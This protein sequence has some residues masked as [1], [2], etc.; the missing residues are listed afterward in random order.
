MNINFLLSIIFIGLSMIYF[1]FKPMKIEKLDSKEIPLFNLSAFTLYELDINSLTS[2]MK[3]SQATRYINRYEVK[4]INYTD[5]SSELQSN[6]KAKNGLYKDE[7][8][9]LDGDVVYDR[10]DGLRYFSQKAVY[11]KGENVIYSKAD[12][13]ATMGENVINGDYIYYDGNKEKIKSNNVY[14]V[15]K[16]KENK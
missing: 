5:N 11:N 3:G 2:L 12:Y 8:V 13:T 14:A 6:M 1:L 15:Y 7:V 16:I 9:Y 4:D 10:V